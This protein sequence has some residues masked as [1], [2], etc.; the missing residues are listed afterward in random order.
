MALQRRLPP[1]LPLQLLL[2]LLPVT[3]LPALMAP[4]VAL[5]AQTDFT[6]ALLA[7]SAQQDDAAATASATTSAAVTVLQED[8]LAV[9][10]TALIPRQ[11]ILRARS[12]LDRELHSVETQIYVWEQTAQNV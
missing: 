7:A 4:K 9:H 3:L 2:L 6:F 1:L 10:S 12:L 5:T 8:I 11:L